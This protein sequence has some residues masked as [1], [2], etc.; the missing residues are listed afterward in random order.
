MHLYL[1][2]GLVAT[3]LAQAPAGTEPPGLP[4]CAPGDLARIDASSD[5]APLITLASRHRAVV[6][7]E[8]HRKR[9]PIALLR[10]LMRR[11]YLEAGYT[12]LALEAQQD[13]QVQIDQFLSGTADEKVLGRTLYTR[14]LTEI[15]LEAR[16]LSQQHPEKRPLKVLLIDGPSAWNVSALEQTRDQRMFAHLRRVFDFD[17]AARVLVFVGNFHTTEGIQLLDGFEGPGHRMDAFVLPVFTLAHLLDLYLGGQ[18][19]SV[20]TIGP[21]DPLGRALSERFKKQER[22][23]IPVDGTALAALRGC[24]EPGG[25]W[26]EPVRHAPLGEVTDYLV[27]F[28]RWTP[29]SPVPQPNPAR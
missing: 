23:G 29:A 7:G 9:E 10:E 15:V 19:L 12:Y 17:P 16:R 24:L 22:L 4:S 28:P 14:E 8:I 20:R 11:L 26:N 6:V 2:T 5:L 21:E 25:R 18:S 27:A 1:L 3:W 13:R